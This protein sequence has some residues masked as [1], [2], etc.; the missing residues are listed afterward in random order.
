VQA[1][2]IRPT[3]VDFLSPVL[4]HDPRALSQGD[5]HRWPTRHGCPVGRLCQLEVVHAS[6]VLDNADAGIAKCVLVFSPDSTRPG[7]LVF[8]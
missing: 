4:M 7:P 5:A 6:N 1:N 2:S 8:Y 3:G